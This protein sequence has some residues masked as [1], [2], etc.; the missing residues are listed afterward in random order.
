M[1]GGFRQGTDLSQN[2]L[3]GLLQTASF[4]NNVQ[5]G[6]SLIQQ[7]QQ[8]LGLRE[9]AQA[10]AREQ[11]A[12][13]LQEKLD[14]KNADSMIANW[15]DSWDG[16]SPPP[17]ELNQYALKASK[18]LR[19]AVF[20]AKGTAQKRQRVQ[21]QLQSARKGGTV[22][23]QSKLREEAEALG[24]DLM[25]TD[26][27]PTEAKAKEEE[28]KANMQFIVRDAVE[29]GLLDP[30]RGERF[31]S[32]ARTDK[33]VQYVHGL[34]KQQ[35]EA[36][37]AQQEAQIQAA[38]QSAIDSRVG[39]IASRLRS[40]QPVTDEERG[41]AARSLNE[42]EQQAPRGSDPKATAAILEN[43]IQNIDSQIADLSARLKGKVDPYTGAVNRKISGEGWF[44]VRDDNAQQ[45]EADAA[46]LKALQQQKQELQ[47]QYDGV[48]AGGAAQPQPAGGQQSAMPPDLIQ[49][50]KAM[51]QRGMTPDQIK[52]SLEADGWRF[53]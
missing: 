6:R 46:T 34:L 44:N 31:V 51:R 10:M 37:K 16:A 50:A 53:E 12:T 21:M 8:E 38:Q 22:Q 17:A 33:D 43:R 48:W 5:Q 19:G 35:A 13:Q 20:D 27:P 14:G 15:L 29:A 32:D 30:K 11:Y 26:F 25:P 3:Q 28:A 42:F 36:A 40:G 9:Q 4:I 39:G 7:R 49:K 41:I 1:L 52:A 23:S 45:V 47:R 24:I 2:Q 18:D